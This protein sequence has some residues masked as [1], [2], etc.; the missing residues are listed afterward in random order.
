MSEPGQAD[1]ALETWRALP[2]G[3]DAA[4]IGE[5]IGDQSRVV[6]KTEPGGEQF[7]DKLEDDP[8]PRIC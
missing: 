3:R 4:I 8:L 7:L 5:I 2:E 1:E 6:L